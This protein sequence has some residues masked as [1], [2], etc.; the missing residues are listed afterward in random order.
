[1]GNYGPDEMAFAQLA[2]VVGALA[3]FVAGLLG[4]LCKASTRFGPRW[5][6]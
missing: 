6:A 5:L 1:M 2:M 4:M 3:D